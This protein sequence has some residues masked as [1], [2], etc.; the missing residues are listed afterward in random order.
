M[1]FTHDVVEE[2]LEPAQ[3]RGRDGDFWTC[4]LVYIMLE[5]IC[6]WCGSHNVH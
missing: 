2:Q 3:P 5:N 1:D 4:A 6:D